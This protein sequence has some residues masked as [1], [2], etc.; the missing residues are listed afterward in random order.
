LSYAS[1]EER[2]ID[3]SFSKRNPFFLGARQFFAESKLKKLVLEC[4][5]R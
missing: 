2:L 3:V 4:R 5:F 1:K